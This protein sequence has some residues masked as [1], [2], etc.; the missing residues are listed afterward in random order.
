[1]KK[2]LK[3]AKLRPQVDG[4]LTVK[5]ENLTTGVLTKNGEA[6]AFETIEG[7]KDSIIIKDAKAGDVYSLSEIQP[8]GE[9]VDAYSEISAVKA[10]VISGSLTVGESAVEDTA[11]GDYLLFKNVAFGEEG[12]KSVILKASAGTKNP[13]QAGAVE[14][15]LDSKN[16][17]LLASVGLADMG[18]DYLR[19]FENFAGNVTGKHNVYLVFTGN[20]NLESLQFF[21]EEQTQV[22]L[23]A[24]NLWEIHQSISM[25]A[26]M[27]ATHTIWQWLMQTVLSGLEELRVIGLSQVTMQVLS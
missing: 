1:M 13:S 8:S 10:D 2:E 5:S 18:T 27:K 12:A 20:A 7:D 17:E 11:R 19:F 6:A 15:R 14:V 16:G 9:N 22:K 21:G 24:Q 26:R 23:P 25:P 3:T 4:D